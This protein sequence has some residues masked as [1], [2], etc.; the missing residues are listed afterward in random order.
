MS[1]IEFIKEALMTVG[2]CWVLDRVLKCILM[3]FVLYKRKM[4]R[5]NDK[6]D[7]I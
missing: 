3:P 1:L 5:I 2:L 7:N 6:S 4:N